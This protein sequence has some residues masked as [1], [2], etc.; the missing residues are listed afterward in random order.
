M[1]IA[2][3]A[4]LQESVPPAAYGG[5]ERIVSWLTEELVH[6]GHDVTL[7]AS[8]DSRTAARLVPVVPHAL[9]PAAVRD[10]QPATM[11]SV[12]RAFERAEEFDVIHAHLDVPAVP[13]ARLVETPVVFTMH[14][15]L[16][17][18]WLR[19]L[20]DA[21][22]DL[23]LV[24]ISDNQR[25]LLPAWH[26]LGTV[27]TGIPLQEYTFQ[28]RG[29]DYLAFLGRLSPEKGVE[30]AIAVARLTGIPLKLAAKL[31]PADEDYYAT[32]L[33][34]LLRDPLVEYIGEVGQE[35]KDAFLG[36]ARALLF[37]IRWPE[38]FGL[39]MAEALAC[40]TPVIAGRFGSVP[41]VIEDGVSGFLCDSVEEMALAVERLDELDRATC[42]AR[43]AER[44]SVAR[45]ADGYEACYQQVCRTGPAT[46]AART[47]LP[48]LRVSTPPP[49][50][51]GH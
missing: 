29:G 10:Y 23:N 37:P 6:R 19:P 13:A 36:R 30:D 41:E 11:L 5:T 38:P 26:W 42:R 33:E 2:Q 25:R 8:G 31:D 46:S 12:A 48:A 47:A 22:P 45:M 1:R 39:V 15:R 24:S 51:N 35:E 20:V 49:L 7:F 14:G 32:R 28:P 27:Y 17:L 50:L 21:Y 3:L 43:V 16:D 34:P 40:G 18:P 4:P 44:F 9:R